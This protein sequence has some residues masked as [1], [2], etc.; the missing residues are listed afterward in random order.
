ML[1][2][3]SA[4]N[5]HTAGH[6]VDWYILSGNNVTKCIQALKLMIPLDAVILRIE[7]YSKEINKDIDKD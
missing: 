6:S 1:A 3:V 5:T 2:G 4:V 7:L